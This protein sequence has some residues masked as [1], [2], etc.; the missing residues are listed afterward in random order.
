MKD[1][2]DLFAKCMRAA[3]IAYVVVF[4]G[5]MAWVAIGP[6]DPKVGS[7]WI[8]GVSNPWVKDTAIRHTVKEIREDWVRLCHNEPRRD[9]YGRLIETERCDEMPI[10]SLRMFYEE[11]EK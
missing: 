11:V 9:D 3:A 7:V 6:S 1:D 8:E 4:V 5:V 10:S 2:T